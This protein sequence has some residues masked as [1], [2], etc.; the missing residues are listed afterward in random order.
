MASATQ[1][2]QKLEHD[3]IIEAIVELRFDVT[4]GSTIPEVFF[5]RLVDHPT[6]KGFQQRRLPEAELPPSLR[7]ADPNL[8]YRPVLHLVE[9]DGPRSLRIGPQVL[10]YHR[11]APYIG[12][13]RFFPE[14]KEVVSELFKKVD[15]LTIRRIGLRYVNALTST[16]HGINVISDLNLTLHVS[17]EVITDSL[18]VNYSTVVSKYIQYTVRVATKEVVK[19]N[20]P[21][22]TSAI[23]DVDVYTTDAFSASDSTA[24]IEWIDAAHQVEKEQFFRLLKPDTIDALKVD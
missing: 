20:I 17:D 2:P 16:L 9:P 1:L 23:I 24:V 22:S 14:L 4:D 7:R 3:A 6:W 12:W 18:N 13:E 15:E 10:S 8:R 5:G 19:G 21:D 11:A